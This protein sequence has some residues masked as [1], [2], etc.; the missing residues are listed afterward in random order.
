MTSISHQLVLEIPGYFT[1]TY[2]SFPYAQSQ[3]HIAILQIMNRICNAALIK[4]NASY[5]H[6]LVCVHIS[7]V[8]IA[9]PYQRYWVVSPWNLR[10]LI[11]I[12]PEAY[13]LLSLFHCK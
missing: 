6:S 3:G 8:S 9:R 2:Y 11:K 1:H 13:E 12:L 7:S 4:F 10:L 5:R